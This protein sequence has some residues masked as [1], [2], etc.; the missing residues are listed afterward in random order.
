[1]NVRSEPGLPV[2]KR[3][4]L[5]RERAGMSRSVLAGLIGR[6]AE[7]VKSV[8]S[9]RLQTPRLAM[10]LKIAQ[11]LGLDDLASLTETGTRS[12]CRSSRAPGIRRCPRYKQR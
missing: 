9:C 2:G 6:S 5:H 1:M 7:W 3:I 10:L 12:R 11:V 8:E 4:K